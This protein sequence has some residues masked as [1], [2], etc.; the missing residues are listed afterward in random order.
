MAEAMRQGRKGFGPL[1]HGC[2]DDDE[3]YGD[4]DGQEDDEDDEEDD[5]DGDAELDEAARMML[6]MEEQEKMYIQQQ[7][8]EREYLKAAAANGHH[9]ANGGTLPTAAQ[10]KMLQNHMDELEDDL[11]DEKII[12]NGG[13]EDE[14]DDLILAGGD[15]TAR[16]GSA[17]KKLVMGE[18][19]YSPAAN[20]HNQSQV[21]VKTWVEWYLIQEDHDFMVDVDHSFVTDKFN[22]IKIR[23]LCG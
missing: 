11:V 22:L 15:G 19:G 2:E 17:Y 1:D 16:N 13:V 9:I 4:E 18:S 12:G 14:G 21:D 23:E 7:M 8:L 20:G 5:E 3:D 10:L 6:M